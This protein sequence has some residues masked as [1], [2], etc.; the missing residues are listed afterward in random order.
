MLNHILL[1]FLHGSNILYGRLSTY[2]SATACT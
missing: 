2:A 1:T